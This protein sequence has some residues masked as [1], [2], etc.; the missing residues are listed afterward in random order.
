MGRLV[1]GSITT[2]SGIRLKAKKYLPSAT[3]RGTADIHAIIKG[4]HVSIEVKIGSDRQSEDQKLEQGRI[5]RAG[6]KY[7]IVKTPE[8]FFELY[9]RMN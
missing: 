2:E 4:F 6:G 7:W 5:E 3:K 8:E 9:H 1:Q